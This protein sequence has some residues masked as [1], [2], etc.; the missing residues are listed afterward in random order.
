MRKIARDNSLLLKSPQRRPCEEK[1]LNEA[2]HLA[3]GGSAVLSGD[4]KWLP[5]SANIRRRSRTVYANALRITRSTFAPLPAVAH[6][7]DGAVAVFADEKTPVFGHCDPDRA[8][9]NFVLRR[10]EA[11]HEVFVFAARFAG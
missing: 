1:D 8:T 2:D 5:K 4:C 7:P 6:S 9:P 11:G 3:V 10:D